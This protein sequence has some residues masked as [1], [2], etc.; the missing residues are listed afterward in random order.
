MAITVNMRT[1]R[2]EITNRRFLKGEGV[3]VYGK[4]TTVSGIG[5]TPGT[6]VRL[7]II[8]SFGNTVFFKETYTNFWGDYDF[9]FRTPNQN[10]NLVAKLF[11]TYTWAGSDEAEV[12]FAVGN[13]TPGTLPNPIAESTWISIVPMVLIGAGIIYAVKYLK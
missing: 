8:D 9:W 4:T 6:F 3:S 13:V 5:I 11:A 2:G 12:P 10:I 7:N 1:Q